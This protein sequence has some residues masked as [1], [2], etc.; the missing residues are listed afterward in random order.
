MENNFINK[1]VAASAVSSNEVL[2][3]IFVDER[4]RSMTV[5]RDDS[6]ILLIPERISDSDMIYRNIRKLVFDSEITEYIADQKQK[7]H[8]ELATK[9]REEIEDAYYNS[10]AISDDPDYEYDGGPY[11]EEL[12]HEHGFDQTAAENPNEIFLGLDDLLE[13]VSEEHRSR[14]WTVDVS[15]TDLLLYEKMRFAVDEINVFSEDYAFTKK[16]RDV[17]RNLISMAYEWG[18]LKKLDDVFEYDPVSYREKFFHQ[19]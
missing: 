6:T 16:N 3:C 5:V 1:P 14:K 7:G 10:Y 17:L 18:Y 9:I 15:H 4:N 11:I 13:V 19:E 2:L 8:Y 12:D